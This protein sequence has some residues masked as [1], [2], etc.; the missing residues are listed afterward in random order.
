MNKVD[1]GGYEDLV[2]TKNL[3]KVEGS[4]MTAL[5]IPKE[6]PSAI[7]GWVNLATIIYMDDESWHYVAQSSIHG[8]RPLES[9]I[10]DVINQ[11]VEIGNIDP[12]RE[13][14]YIAIGYRFSCTSTSAPIFFL[15]T[16]SWAKDKTPQLRSGGALP[17][18][19]FEH[20][21]AKGYM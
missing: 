11:S 12:T 15:R 2:S 4:L 14:K 13:G 8:H 3:P 20:L 1:I 18:S 5:E 19:L 21:K 10:R 16:L 7:L 6:V 9:Y 17:E